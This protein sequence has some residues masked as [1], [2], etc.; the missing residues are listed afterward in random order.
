MYQYLNVIFRSIAYTAANGNN[1]LNRSK[2]NYEGAKQRQNRLLPPDRSPQY[3]NQKTGTS[4][5][6][7]SSSP[8][9]NNTQNTSLIGQ[10]TN[11]HYA[12]ETTKVSC[13]KQDEPQPGTKDDVRIMDTSN[14]SRLTFVCTP[15]KSNDTH[16]PIPPT[17]N[18]TSHSKESNH[19]TT[20]ITTTPELDVKVNSETL[21]T[22]HPTTNSGCNISYCTSIVKSK[23]E[24]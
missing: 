1:H 12:D 9:T 15:T 2:S 4:K 13:R 23:S 14:F 8:K 20:N 3:K 21:V 24:W 7:H 6:N 11:S 22:N 5:S 17:T 16:S 10:P 18:N 19:I